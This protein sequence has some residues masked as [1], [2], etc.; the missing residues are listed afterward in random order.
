MKQVKLTKARQER[1]LE[2][3][4]DTGS[5][6]TAAAVAGTSRTRVYELRKKD[7]AFAAAWEE[8]E[9][10]ATDMLE[11]EARRRA[12]EGIAEPL[13]IGGKLVRGDD[14]Q[15]VIVRRYSDNLL[16]SLLKLRRLPRRGRSLRF[17]LPPVRSLADAAS[18]M[19]AITAAVAAGELTPGEAAEL[20]KLV[21][22]DLDLLEAYE[23]EQRAR[24][25]EERARK[26]EEQGMMDE[27]LD[28]GF[29]S[30]FLSHMKSKSR[31]RLNKRL[32]KGK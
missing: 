24:T 5:V 26:I 16:L 27:P 32:A 6:T 4:A 18:A 9:E 22:A 11:E 23:F 15:P 21:G 20:S 30:P 8:A 25:L 19:A 13:V 14:G 7:T 1:F 12:I 31:E 3:L 28:A 17:Q 29:P 10:I 2:A